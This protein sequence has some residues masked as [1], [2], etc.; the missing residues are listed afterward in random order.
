M[1]ALR[2]PTVTPAVKAYQYANK[3]VVK[4]YDDGSREILN[5]PYCDWCGDIADDREELPGLPSELRCPECQTILALVSHSR[6][7]RI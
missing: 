3:I 2:M 6:A 7:K 1:H 4:Y 5:C